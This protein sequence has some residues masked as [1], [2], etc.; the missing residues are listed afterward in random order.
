MAA[1]Y[2]ELLYEIIDSNREMYEDTTDVALGCLGDF[3]H[4]TKNKKG[5]SY[6]LSKFKNALESKGKDEGESLDATVL[7]DAL[8]KVVWGDDYHDKD[9]IVIT[10]NMK[11][12]QDINA[13][14]IAA[15]EKML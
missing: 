4:V 3:C 13:N 7:Y 11:I 9:R 14:L 12:P 8:Q 6:L 5:I 1:Q 10:S 2:E 15:V